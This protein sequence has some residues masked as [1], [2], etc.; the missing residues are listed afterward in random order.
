MK[1]ERC[2]RDDALWEFVRANLPEDL[3]AR[4]FR[5]S[6]GVW[7]AVGGRGELGQTLWGRWVESEPRGMVASVAAGT[8]EIYD[9][10]WLSDFEDLARRYDEERG[11]DTT[12]RYWE[13]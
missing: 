11:T 1:I 5:H 13:G 10:K 12:I 9:P 2:I 8:I 4:E 7:R 3:V 6:Y